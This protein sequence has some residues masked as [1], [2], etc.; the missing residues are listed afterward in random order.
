MRK[1]IRVQKQ[2]E[3]NEIWERW[4]AK[5]IHKNKWKCEDIYE[6]NDL[7]HDAYLVFRHVKATYPLISEPKHLMALYQTALRYELFDKAKQRQQKS[8]YE[9][10]LEYAVGEDLTL[11]DTLGEPNNEGYLNL[12]I[13]ELPQELKGLLALFN[14]PAKLARLRNMDKRSRLAALAGIQMRKLSLNDAC[15]KMLGLPPGTDLQAKLQQ[16]LAD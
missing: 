3:W 2:P 13:S 16:A 4:T 6:F 7:M 5:F 8:M 11:I 9:V 12:L 10:S 15:C 1:R 14:D